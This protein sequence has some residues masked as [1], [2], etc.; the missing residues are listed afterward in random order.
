MPRPARRTKHRR[1]GYTD[2][3]VQHCLSGYY[4]G[5]GHGF[6]KLFPS[7]DRDYTD[8]DAMRQGW[9]DLRGE[10][11]PKFIESNPGQRPHAWWLFDAPE[12]RRR[13]DG[14]QHPF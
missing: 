7:H 2:E 5:P 1:S 6:T 8:Y 9:E 12:R 3:D 4:M 13:I 14:V 11:L 10:L